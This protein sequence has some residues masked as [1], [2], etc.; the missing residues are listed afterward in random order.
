M[1]KMPITVIILTKNAEATLEKTLESVAFAAEVVAIDDGS[2]DHTLEILKHNHVKVASFPDTDFAAKRTKA[3]SLTAHE[4]VLYVDADEVVT[5]ALARKVTAIVTANQPGA[6]RIKRRNMFLGTEMY[7]DY[8][9]R[10]FHTSIISGW[11]GRVHESPQ[12][13][14]DP[15]VLTESLLHDAHR[16]ITSMLDK[17][18][19]WSEYEADLRIEA[20]HPPVHWW[21]LIRIGL[22]LWWRQFIVMGIGT[23]GRAGLFEGYFQIVDKLIVYTKLWERQKQ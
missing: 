13:S 22:T 10:L 2:T 3:L 16:D 8:V 15:T 21:R 14:V 7:P 1:E 11:Q 18:N 20:H 9:D 12:L 17:T 5:S 23:Y 19:A 4:W 6:F